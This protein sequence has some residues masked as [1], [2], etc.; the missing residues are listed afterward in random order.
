MVLLHGVAFPVLSPLKVYLKPKRE[1]VISQR[2]Q[3][4]F[5]QNLFISLGSVNNQDI[6]SIKSCR[7]LPFFKPDFLRKSDLCFSLFFP[8]ILSLHICQ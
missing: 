1:V 4:A 7:E 6:F 2:S 8:L 3:E 5:C